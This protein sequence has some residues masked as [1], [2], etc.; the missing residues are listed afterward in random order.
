MEKL[1]LLLV[2]LTSCAAPTA[3]M[4]H[5]GSGQALVC[6]TWA[7]GIFR[8]ITALIS[9]ARC[10]DQARTAGFVKAEEYGR[11]NRDYWQNPYR[12]WRR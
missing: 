5:P 4:V 10:V 6:K 9:N 2:L 1:L 12:G 8:P 3:V 7:V 11:Y